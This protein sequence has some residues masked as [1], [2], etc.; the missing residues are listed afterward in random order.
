MARC[1]VPSVLHSFAI[2]RG[3]EM[4]RSDRLRGALLCAALLPLSIADAL[5]QEAA[6]PPD[7]PTIENAARTYTPEDFKRFAPNNALDML[8]QVPGFVIRNAVQERGLGQATGNVLING[9][10]LSAKSQD[11][12]GQ[13]GRIPAGNVVRI[14]IRDGATMDI[15]GLSGQVANVIT[16][17]A[18][19]SGQWEWRP[20][21]RARYTNPQVTRGNV[22]VSGAVG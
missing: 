8:E 11:V 15:S 17:A 13:L 18:G 9:Q 12:L 22:S 1:A 16:K 3:F 6:A 20:D 5:A 19:V 2:V 21:V 10:R 7:K 4:R 14:E